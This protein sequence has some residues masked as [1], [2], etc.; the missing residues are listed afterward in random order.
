M[1]AKRTMKITT[2]NQIEAMRSMPSVVAKSALY[3]SG[4]GVH[5]DQ[6]KGYRRHGKHK[7]RE[8]E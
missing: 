7:G 8:S 4:A 6:G 1:M 5:A 2:P 3:R